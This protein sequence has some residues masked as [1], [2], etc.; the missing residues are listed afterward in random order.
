[1]I[2][3][4]PLC[5]LPKGNLHKYEWMLD[6]GM[7]SLPEDGNNGFYKSLTLFPI[8][9]FI[10]LAWL[11]LK[12]KQKEWLI[13]VAVGAALFLLWLQKFWF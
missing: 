6:E 8:L 11:L 3:G 12:K 2:S 9:V 7:T 13:A 10:G 1:M 5:N 4:F